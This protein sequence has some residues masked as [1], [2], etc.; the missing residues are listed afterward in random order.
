MV[1]PCCRPYPLWFDRVV[2]ALIAT[3]HFDGKSDGRGRNKQGEE[4]EHAL[5][6]DI[7]SLKPD[8]SI[9]RQSF[10][11]VCGFSMMEHVRL[12][13]VYPTE[14]WLGS[15]VNHIRGWET[16]WICWCHA[17]EKGC[18]PEGHR[19]A[20]PPRSSHCLAQWVHAETRPSCA[21][22]SSTSTD[23]RVRPP[24]SEKWPWG[25]FTLEGFHI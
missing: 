1:G 4:D 20:A 8:S 13:A 21:S 19:V 9:F 17:L 5:T 6:A 14:N 18:L 15:S 10:N 25:E 16:V 2:V 23:Q 12:C 11:P 22:M 7:L 3:W 24:T